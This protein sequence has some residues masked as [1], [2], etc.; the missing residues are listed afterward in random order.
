MF[1]VMSEIMIHKW[2]VTYQEIEFPKW[3]LDEYLTPP[4]NN[5]FILASSKPGI[6]P[7]HNPQ[8]VLPRLIKFCQTSGKLYSSYFMCLKHTILEIMANSCIVYTHSHIQTCGPLSTAISIKALLYAQ[9]CLTF[10]QQVLK[11]LIIKHTRGT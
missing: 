2:R 8:E 4:W 10:I 11:E 9:S 6:M 1:V 3:F 7:T 5:W